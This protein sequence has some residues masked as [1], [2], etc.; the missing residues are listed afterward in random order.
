MELTEKSYAKFFGE[1]MRQNLEEMEPE[2][3]KKTADK[4][5]DEPTDK[6][7]DKSA[8]KPVGKP[9]NKG[10]GGDDEEVGMPESD[11][12]KPFHDGSE[13]QE[14]G[15]DIEEEGGTENYPVLHQFLHHLSSPMIH[16]KHMPGHTHKL[17]EDYDYTNDLDDDLL[18]LLAEVAPGV[19]PPPKK[20]KQEAPA[21]KAQAPAAPEKKLSSQ[22]LL[23]KKKKT[24]AE[25]KAALNSPEAIARRE[26]F[27]KEIERMQGEGKAAL[28]AR[29]GNP[30]EHMR[31]GFH[32]AFN[33]DPK[34]GQQGP[35]EDD[36][37]R[38]AKLKASKQL[39]QNF[40]VSRG[41]M[42][43]ETA[44]QATMF[45]ENHKTQTSAGVGYKTIGLSLAPSHHS[46]YEH[47]MCPNA[48]KECRDNCLGLKAGGNRQFPFATLRAKILRT[49]FIH[50]H[51]EEAARLLHHEI[52]KNEKAA[53]AIGFKSGIRMNVTSDV[54]YEHLMPKQ[55]FKE[56]EDRPDKPGTQF[57]DYTK[58]HGRLGH[59]DMP[60][61]YAL[62]LSHTGTGHGESNDK[63]AVKH[64]NNGGV[65][66][67]VYQRGKGVPTPTHVEDV[68]TGKRWRI[69]NG[70]NDDNVFDRHASIQAPKGEGVVSGLALKGVSNK[71]AGHFANVVDPDGVIRINKGQQQPLTQISGL[72]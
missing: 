54:P 43:P 3:K 41:K 60:S 5:S 65:V 4:P 64:L 6:P 14:S 28:A 19:A 52:G 18:S 38:N 33:V 30:F 68:Q 29:G 55:F 24:Y 49:H 22:A 12:E 44:K 48:S 50:E 11:K 13:P 72:K 61:N 58:M 40:L 57:Y 7:D 59:K 26:G 20:K 21:P 67:M 46:G 9:V 71:Q 31:R 1:A 37:T 27:Q 8:G 25:E 51:P 35:Q 16:P 70:D 69:A 63:Q 23:G 56:H 42:K 10:D 32:A 36:A 39:F 53:N 15:E 45:G 62:A 2:L 66:A 34:T 17:Y 47:D